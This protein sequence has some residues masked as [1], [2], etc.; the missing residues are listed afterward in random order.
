MRLKVTWHADVLM[1]RKTTTAV[2]GKQ[3]LVLHSKANF[4][5][6]FTGKR[7]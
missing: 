3:G 7:K 4:I 5:T 6:D 2:N 1:K